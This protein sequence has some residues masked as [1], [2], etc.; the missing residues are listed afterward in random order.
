[1]Q[2]FV[3]LCQSA[4][5]LLLFVQKKSKMAAAVILNFIFVQY[6][7]M[8]MCKTSNLIS[9]PNLEQIRSTVNGL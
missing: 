5:E 8:Y 3:Y 1:M 9:M 4:S 6:F 7:R 2:N